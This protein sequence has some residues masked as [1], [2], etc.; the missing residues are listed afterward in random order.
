MKKKYSAPESSI[1][2]PEIT[3]LLAASQESIIIGNGSGDE[4]G[5]KSINKLIFD[6]STD[7]DVE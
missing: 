7:F 5:A 1:I 4:A 3:T 2:V 6:D